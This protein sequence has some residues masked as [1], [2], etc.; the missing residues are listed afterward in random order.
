MQTEGIYKI[1]EESTGGLFPVD[2]RK[3]FHIETIVVEDCKVIYVKS[4][5]V[6]CKYRENGMNFGGLKLFNSALYLQILEM[7]PTAH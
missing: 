5:G 1:H 2:D 6:I 7:L 3:F 4:N